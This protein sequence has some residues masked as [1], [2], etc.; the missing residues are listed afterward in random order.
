MKVVVINAHYTHTLGGSEI[1]CHQ[2][3]Y[4]LTELGI[5]L[6]YLAVGGYDYSIDL[7][8]KVIA[9]EKNS[10]SIAQVCKELQTDVIYWRFNKNLLASVINEIKPFN[11]R[12]IFSVSHI[13]D[14]KPF[15][16]K[17]IPNLSVF[18]RLKRRL[19]HLVKGIEFQRAFKKI[20]GV[21][22]NNEEHLDRIAHTN[23]I[24]IPNSPFL[25]FEEFS[26]PKPYVVWVGNI[27]AHK[28]PELFIDLAKSFE[29]QGVDF[30]MV[31]DI[32]QQAYEYLNTSKELPGN[33]YYLGPKRIF[34]TNGVIRSSLFLIHTCEPEG[35]PNVFLQAWSFK[36]PVVSAFFD[37]GSMIE[38]HDVGRISNNLSKLYTDVEQLIKDQQLRNE[39][40]LRA[41]DLIDRE[42]I[43]TSNVK[44]LLGFIKQ[45]QHS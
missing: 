10:K 25:E 1:Q 36:K 24:Y 16:Y 30:L 14:L 33:F 18:D 4:G 43:R 45:S 5:D 34:E 35:F 6:T 26:W 27:K 9:V 22:C 13:H 38:K 3:A 31:G 29:R 23:K 44:K 8:Y 20:D 37:P 32:Q 28:H 2:I 42:F 7:P 15:A 39:I 41:R 11:I 21:V 17:P 12:L 19:G 40:G